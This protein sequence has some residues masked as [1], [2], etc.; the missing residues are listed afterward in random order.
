[1]R[2]VI[3]PRGAGAAA[4]FSVVYFGLTL[5]VG[6]SSSFALLLSVMMLML[7]YM[8]GN[9][10]FLTFH[11]RLSW[12]RGVVSCLFGF[13]AAGLVIDISL[14]QWAYLMAVFITA[15]YVFAKIACACL[16]CCGITS[17][18]DKRFFN[19]PLRPRLQ[20]FELVISTTF[21]YLG[22]LLSFFDLS[23]AAAVMVV[24]HASIR[25]F[26]ARFRFP[27]RHPISFVF[28]MGTGGLSV[29]FIVFLLLETAQ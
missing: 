24:G 5:I 12:T 18:K 13:G 27:Y 25:V 15:T 11:Q 9:Y 19:W 10:S 14:G 29:L 22:S 21:L 7:L 26:A 28:E 3:I 8:G 23:L 4:G 1:M 2:G 6:T 16:G 17:I 20:S